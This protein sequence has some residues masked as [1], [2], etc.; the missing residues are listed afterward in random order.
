MV[1]SYVPLPCVSRTWQTFSDGLLA[2][3]VT[4]QGVRRGRSSVASLAFPGDVVSPGNK[5]QIAAC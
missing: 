3:G 2:L 1:S 4:P 5:V